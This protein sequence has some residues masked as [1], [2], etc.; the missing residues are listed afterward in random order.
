MIILQNLSQKWNNILQ[1][2]P[3]KVKSYKNLRK[4][5]KELL[6]MSPEMSH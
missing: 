3:Q 6:R 2:L 1:N 4:M 5:K